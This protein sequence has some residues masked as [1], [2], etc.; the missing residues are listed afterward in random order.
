MNRD[1]FPALSELTLSPKFP[2]VD[3]F[4]YGRRHDRRPENSKG[5]DMKIS[6]IAS[7]ITESLTLKLNATA[8]ALKAK[9]EPIIH[10]GGG[11][12]KSKAPLGAIEAGIEMLKTGEVRYTPE[13]GTPAMKQAV[14]D[15]T[16][17][18]YGRKVEPANVLVSSGAKQSIIVGLQAVLDPGDEMIY[19]RPYW[20]SYPDMARL[21][22]ATGVAVAASDGSLR[23]SVADMAAAVTPKTKI[24][25]INSPNNPSGVMYSADFI[26]AMVELCEQ[27][28]IYLMMDDIY[29]RLV[30]DGLKPI[31]CYDFTKKSVDESNIIVINGVSKQYAMTGFRIGWAVGRR[32]LIKVMSM[33]QGHETSGASSLSQHCAVGALKGAQESVEELR[34]TLEQ[35]RNVLMD[36][37]AT[38]E[39][40]HVDKPNGTFYS[41][42]DFSRFDKDSLKLAEYL[43]EKA[44]V[45][46]VPG[47]A[48]GMDGYLRISYCGGQ[49]DIVEGIKRIKQAL[50]A[51]PGKK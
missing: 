7:G 17:K 25:L 11:E 24:M 13:S 4:P 47:M 23:P 22:G 34:K 41:F 1:P 18:H 44:K 27:R 39:G 48:F 43:I 6:K 37:L 9:G 40:V 35:N 21:C 32:D 28:G 36:C 15:Y 50:A 5:K 46:T 8:N 51:Y 20:V 3:V 30:F 10:L 12:P 38:I 31:N 26:K 33:I 19:P 42:A 2:S 16:A 14:I 45:V 49:N 29:H